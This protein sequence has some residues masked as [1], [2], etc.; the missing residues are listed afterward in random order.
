M[1]SIHAGTSRLN[2]DAADDECVQI[3]VASG[4][5]AAAAADKPNSVAV[6]HMQSRRRRTSHKSTTP[7]GRRQPYNHPAPRPLHPRRAASALRARRYVNLSL[8]SITIHHRDRAHRGFM[9]DSWEV[10][11]ISTVPWT[12]TIRIARAEECGP[13]GKVIIIIIIHLLRNM[14]SHKVK[15]AYTK[16]KIT[17]N[18]KKVQHEV[19]QMY[20]TCKHSPCNDGYHYNHFNMPTNL[21]L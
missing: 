14:C 21:K 13:P 16:T 8:K 11:Y 4:Q 12:E 1:R 7:G 17:K 9:S 15:Y 3:S 10:S 5:R 2:D 20:I 6:I 18:T 19:R